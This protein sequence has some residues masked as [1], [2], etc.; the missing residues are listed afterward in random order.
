MVSEAAADMLLRHCPACTWL[1]D[2][3]LEFHAA[4]GN[5]TALFGRAAS[6]LPGVNF[7]HLVSADTRPSW[8]KRWERVLAG[9]TL[10][11]RER[12][13][14]DSPTCAITL[15]PV[16]AAEGHVAFAGGLAQ[17]SDEHGLAVRI[18]RARENER[19]HLAQLL[20][21][22][23]AQHLSAAGLQLDLLHMELEKS[24]PPVAHRT[25]EIQ[26]LLES[27]MDVVRGFSH[28]LNPAV[29]ERVG[30]PTALDTMAGLLRSGF[31][32]NVRLLADPSARPSV[33][34]AVAFYRIAREATANAARHAGC[35][36]I[37]ILLKSTR[38]GPALEVRDNGQGFDA[39]ANTSRERGLGLMLME[40]YA[41]Q[42]GIDLRIESSSA[43]GTVVR[44][45][46]RT[47]AAGAG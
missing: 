7:A 35:S 9:D 14:A 39:S 29:V 46:C 3:S 13:T 11:A 34:A 32:G 33:P 23:A 18:H 21:D 17:E 25:A 24:A 40:Q 19:A 42:A 26:T 22:H 47:A 45:L 44:A 2:P 1:L 4:Y 30:L 41:E 28:E 8:I 43:S 31:R 5:A 36:V 6:E 15:F 37:E 16:R 38:S 12:L 10:H 27:V 20:H